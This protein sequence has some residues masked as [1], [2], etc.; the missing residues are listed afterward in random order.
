MSP[1]SSHYPTRR[2][3]L[4]TTSLAV[5]GTVLATRGVMAQRLP[6]SV[7]ASRHPANAFLPEP[8]TSLDLRALATNAIDAAKNAG[9]SYADVRV[10]ERHELQVSPRGVDPGME[11]TSTVTYG[12][13]VL[14]DGAWAFTHGVIPTVDAL[15]TAARNAVAMARGYARFAAPRQELVPVSPATGEWATPI[16]EDPFTVPLQDHAALLHAYYR[17]CEQVRYARLERI[18]CTWTKERRVFASTDGGLTMQTFHRAEPRASVVGDNDI[19]GRVM[20]QFPQWG[21]V[22]GGFDAVNGPVLQEGLKRWAEE[23][24]RLAFLSRGTVDVGRY[25]VVLNGQSFGALLGKTLGPAL[26]LDRVLG[27][28]TDASGTSYLTPDLLGTQMAHEHF[29][30]MGHRAIPSASAVKWDDEGVEPQ[31]YPLITEGRLVDFHTSRHTAPALQDWYARRGV[32]MRSHGCAMAVSADAPVMV[33]PPHLV[34]T[35]SATVASLD[36]LC[37]GI[38]RGLLLLDAQQWETDQQL[39]SVSGSVAE[40]VLSVPG[41]MLEIRQGRPVRRIRRSGLELSSKTLWKEQLVALGDASTVQTVTFQVTKGLP[42]QQTVQ[43][44]TMPAALL[45]DV[46]VVAN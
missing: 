28:E 24:V 39:V 23:V 6:P 22:S 1:C 7:R 18:E 14:V 37:K 29:T 42:R 25:P 36:D 45:K 19:M 16:G 5:A 26:E 15:A 9:A 31:A 34:V 40:R 38:T 17:A 21:A 35:P 2:D 27:E 10:G 13:R 4:T 46:N 8:M 32:P 43:S 3:F 30:L 33:R 11:L 20:L 12:V 41:I 44:T